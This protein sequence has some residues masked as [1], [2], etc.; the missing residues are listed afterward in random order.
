MLVITSDIA[1]ESLL[2]IGEIAIQSGLPTKTIRYYEEI[3]L[4]VPNVERSASGYRLF[5]TSVLNRLAFIKRAQ[6]LGLSLQEIQT[7]LGVHDRGELPCDEVKQH[8]HS[9]LIAI[10]QQITALETLKEEL[11]GILCGW[12]EKPSSDRIA[13]TICPN[14]QK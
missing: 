11:Q 2:K 10:A 13:Q 12:E 14:L 8:I 6:A 3:G 4:L 9:K 5:H 1:S 7:I